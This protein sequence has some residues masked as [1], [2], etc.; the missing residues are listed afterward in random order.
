M[1]AGAVGGPPRRTGD[2]QP[3]SGSTVHQDIV[4]VNQHEV[5]EVMVEHLSHVAL[6]YGGALTRPYGITRYS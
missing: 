6:E 3:R 5:V 1:L 4:N 2:V